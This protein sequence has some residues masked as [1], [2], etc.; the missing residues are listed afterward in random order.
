MIT[1]KVEGNVGT[2]SIYGSPFTFVMSDDG[3][4]LKREIVGTEVRNLKRESPSIALV[5]D[6]AQPAAA[7]AISLEESRA[8]RHT[9][10]QMAS[11]DLATRGDHGTI[12]TPV[13]MVVMDDEPGMMSGLARLRRRASLLCWTAAAG[14][15]VR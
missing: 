15:Y 8:S 12:Y 13:T 1:G 3:M 2:G 6:E 4:Y 14:A 11:T 5:T 10:L 7:S 9:S